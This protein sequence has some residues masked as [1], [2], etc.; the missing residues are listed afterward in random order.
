MA[1]YLSPTVP[2]ARTFWYTGLGCFLGSVAVMAFGAYFATLEPALARNPGTGVA[3]LFGP[4]RPLIPGRLLPRPPRPI[5]HPGPV[6][7]QLRI[8]SLSLADY[9]H[10]L[11]GCRPPGTVRGPVVLRRSR[12]ATIG[13]RH[14]VAAGAADPGRDPY[15]RRARQGATSDEGPDPRSYI[16]IRPFRFWGRRS[17]RR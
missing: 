14:R 15:R 17:T 16:T 6:R 2:P 9:R 4:A 3:A 5:Q 11:R 7:Q 1:V 8:R 13:Y 12:S 10:I